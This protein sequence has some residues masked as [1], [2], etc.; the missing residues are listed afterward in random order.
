M[1]AP[2]Y[3]VYVTYH[4]KAY[5]GSDVFKGEVMNLVF[6]PNTPKGLEKL[7]DIIRRSKVTTSKI[8]I[9]GMIPLAN[10]PAPST[11]DDME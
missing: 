1:G 5:D 6:R 4:Y 7:T 9:L 2:K 10:D 3:G 11:D 8:T